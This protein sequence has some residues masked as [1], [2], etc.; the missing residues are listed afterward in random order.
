MKGGRPPAPAFQFPIAGLILFPP[1]RRSSSA[2]A[3]HGLDS[4]VETL[5]DQR[6]K[7]GLINAQL[8]ESSELDL[9]RPMF[10]DGLRKPEHIREGNVQSGRKF[11]R[12]THDSCHVGRNSSGNAASLPLDS[13]QVVARQKIVELLGVRSSAS[14]TAAKS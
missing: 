14:A 6:A 7:R 2:T 12:E 3:S 10:D 1:P 13:R 4:R 11:S 9:L 5:R 8:R